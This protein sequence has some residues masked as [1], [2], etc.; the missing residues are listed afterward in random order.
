MDP[1]P[2]GGD[3]SPLYVPRKRRSVQSQPKSGVP[4]PVVVQRIPERPCDL[5]AAGYPKN[6]ESEAMDALKMKRTYGRKRYEDL[7][8]V[9][10]GAVDYPTTSCS[11]VMSSGGLANGADPD[12][13]APP[14][15][16]LP[17]SA[18]PQGPET[19]RGPN[20]D[21]VWSSGRD[22]LG[23]SSQDQVWMPGRDRVQDQDWS[24]GR[25]RGPSED[26]SW[27]PGRSQDPPWNHTRGDRGPV[28]RPDLN[29]KKVLR[30]E[31]ERSPPVNNFSPPSEG[32][33]ACSEAASVDEVPT[34]QPSEDQKPPP[35]KKEPPTYPPGSPEEC[36]QLQIVAKGRVTCPK[37]K[38]VSRKTVEGLKKHMENCR[39]VSTRSEVSQS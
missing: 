39:L 36:W 27:G 19:S 30:V 11:V 14:P 21:Q 28:W 16:R 8:S 4:C 29:M 9:P 5:N 37:C 22:R 20:Q 18:W 2:I 31:M 15:A 23:H 33:D 34:V 6:D 10:I 13:L 38:S 7:Q 3:M 35:T 26:Q 24:A 17:L 12:S 25:E 1:A 32:R